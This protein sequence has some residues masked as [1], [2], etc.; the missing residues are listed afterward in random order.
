MCGGSICGMFMC[1]VCVYDCVC[2][3]LCR[4]C[5]NDVV[6]SVVCVCGMCVFV[7]AC[8]VFVKYYLSDT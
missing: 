7:C 2:G 3:M 5:V 6:W 1:V 4:C 8:V